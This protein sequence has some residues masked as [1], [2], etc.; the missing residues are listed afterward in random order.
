MR[1]TVVDGPTY[2]LALDELEQRHER[3]AGD[4][5]VQ[6]RQKKVR[7]RQGTCTLRYK[8]IH[9]YSSYR[10]PRQ[11]TEPVRIPATSVRPRAPPTEAP[12]L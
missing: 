7:R 10:T 3:Q 1:T 9:R 12:S 11:V 6:Q 2:R 4:S 5:S 8:V